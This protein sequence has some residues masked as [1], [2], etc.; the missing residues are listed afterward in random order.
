MYLG[1]QCYPISYIIL[2]FTEYHTDLYS[3]APL[4][5]KV[6]QAV[7]RDDDVLPIKILLEHLATDSCP[8]YA[9]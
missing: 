3:I 2:V 1:T 9:R 7:L 4:Q 5:Q 6:L 8:E